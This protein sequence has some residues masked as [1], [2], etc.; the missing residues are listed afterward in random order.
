MLYTSLVYV[1]MFLR[2]MKHDLECKICAE[3]SLPG[4]VALSV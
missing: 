3:K 4:Y 2:E 1:L